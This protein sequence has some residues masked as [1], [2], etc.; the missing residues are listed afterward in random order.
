MQVTIPHNLPQNTLSQV[1][2]ML[3]EPQMEDISSIVSEKMNLNIN[4]CHD[5]AHF[6]HFQSGKKQCMSTKKHLAN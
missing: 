5:L 1:K 4:L 2:K 3:L 6:W